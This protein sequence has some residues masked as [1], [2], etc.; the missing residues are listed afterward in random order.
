VVNLSDK[1]FRLHVAAICHCGENLTDGKV[2]PKD[3][4]IVAP[5]A[6]AKRPGALVQELVTA[7]LWVPY[8]DPVDGHEIHDYL[9]YNPPRHEV[10]TKRARNAARQRTHRSVRNG[11][12]DVVT[13]DVSHLGDSVEQEQT[14]GKTRGTRARDE[15]WD[16]L[17]SVLGSQPETD[18]ERGRWNKALKDIRDAG[19]TAQDIQARA[20]S[21]RQR[22]PDAALTPTALSANWGSLAPKRQASAPC[23]HCGVGAGQHAADCPVVAPFTDEDVKRVAGQIE[24]HR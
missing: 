23:E 11:V 7:D 16:A 13:H 8:D 17:A 4:S 2:T 19:G 18:S 3:L 5:L 22:Y 24:A 21:Y 12:T 14:K 20:K 10:L 15:L 6:G 1:A 9:V